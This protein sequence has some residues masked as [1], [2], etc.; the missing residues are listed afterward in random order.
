MKRNNHNTFFVILKMIYLLIYDSVTF[1]NCNKRI[2][3]FF[4]LD[5]IRW[6]KFSTLSLVES[7]TVI[8]INLNRK[9]MNI[10]LIEELMRIRNFFYYSN[11]SQH[12]FLL[13]L[14]SLMNTTL[15]YFSLFCI[16]NIFDFNGDFLF[17][18]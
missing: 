1:S 2:I 13:F 10:D 18:H 12:K 15:F 5:E 4:Y 11:N 8:L 17:Y 14:L 3:L 9:L 6:R 7:K 16:W